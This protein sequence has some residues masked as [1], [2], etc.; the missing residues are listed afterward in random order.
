[1]QDTS[2]QYI[3]NSKH[4]QVITGKMYI[5]NKTNKKQTFTFVF[6]QGNKTAKIKTGHSHWAPAAI[7][8]ASPDEHIEVPI[9]INWKPSEGEEL[10]IFPINQTDKTDQYNGAALGLVRFFV[11][12]SKHPTVSKKMIDQQAFQ[13][14]K[15]FNPEKHSLL[16]VLDWYKQASHPVKFIEKNGELFSKGKVESLRIRPLPYHTSVDIVLVDEYGNTEEL[17]KHVK[18]NKEES[19]EIKLDKSILNHVYKMEQR[20]FI[21]AFNNRNK[22]ILADAKAVDKMKKPVPTTS[23]SVIELYRPLG[24]GS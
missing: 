10:T 21:V 14:P 4:A 23:Q 2:F 24:K 6:L 19:H 1:M 18:I 7:L 15:N 16:P 8:E 22:K 3:D 9:K 13:L 12:K 11:S 17:A 5:E 20:Q